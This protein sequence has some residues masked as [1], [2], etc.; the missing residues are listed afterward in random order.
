MVPLLQSIPFMRIE[1]ESASRPVGT[2]EA[3]RGHDPGPGAARERAECARAPEGKAI[4]FGGTRLLV[5]TA[6]WTDRTL[7][8]KG[9]FYPEAAT[10]PEDR[11]RYYATR[12]PLVEVDATYYALPTRRMAEAWAERTPDDFTFDVKANALMTGHPTEVSR[13]P[14]EIRDALPP[15][16]AGK[17][18]IYA[19]DLPAE[20]DEAVWATFLDAL[21]PLRSSGKLGGVLLQYPRWF[22]PTR[23]NAR[24]LVEAKRRLGD[25][26][27]TVEFRNR[28]WFSDRLRERTLALLA[29]NAIPFVMV[30][31]PQ[32]HRS[33]VPPIVAATSPRLA[34]LRLHGRRAETWETQ[35][36]SVAE[37]FRY[38]YDRGE[39]AEWLPRLEH[40]AAAAREVHVVFNNC[41]AN[42]GTTNAAEMMEMLA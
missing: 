3:D 42:Y 4:E 34:V 36:V 26:T 24:L 35:K 31:A 6:G 18:R 21:E 9:V 41:Y 5:G 11:L 8:A 33:S 14:K 7:T 29:D 2:S 38:L 40:A 20:L 1:P 16:L 15:E 19:K 37:R 39:L 25:V 12:F 28:D 13:L 22:G 23:D 27:G 32:G 17:A 10:T 30:D